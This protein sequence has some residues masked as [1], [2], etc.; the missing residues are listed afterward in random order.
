MNWQEVI[1]ASQALAERWRGRV[2]QVYGIPTGGAP[3]ALIVSHTLGIPITGDPTAI[4]RTLIVDD[5]VDT[6]DTLLR[7]P[8]EY[9]DACFRKP[10]SPK[11]LA[12]HAIETDEWLTFPWENHGGAPEDNIT[13]ILQYLGQDPTR[14]GLLDTPKRVLK[15][16]KEMTSGY[17]ADPETILSTVFTE[18]YDQMVVLTGIEFVSL[19]EHHLLP[20]RGTATVGYIP[21]GKVVGLSKLA[22]LV[23]AYA[24]RLQVQ[25]RMTEQIAEAITEH[26]APIGVGVYITA[27]HSCMGNRGVRKHDATMATQALHGAMLNDGNARAEFMRLA[28]G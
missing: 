24:R 18:D 25:E 7:Q 3:V 26:L 6:G 15:A 13:R 21:N 20:F 22:R 27:H 12:P 11:H 2:D 10:W 5:L 16:L 1:S 19:C 14:E 28:Q 8:G 4:P 23:D 9:K 17:D